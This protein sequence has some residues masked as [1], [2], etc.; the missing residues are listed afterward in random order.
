VFVIGGLALAILGLTYATTLQRSGALVALALFGQACA[1]Q[2]I[3][4]PAYDVYQHF[5]P[6][7]DA[8]RSAYLPFVLGLGAQTIIVFA[9]ASRN[10]RALATRLGQV[11]RPIEAAALLALLGFGAVV[12]SARPLQIGW[13]LLLTAWVALVGGLNVILAVEHLPSGFASGFVLKR[14][15]GSAVDLDNA[16][17]SLSKPFPWI[18]AAWTVVVSALLAWFVFE[19]VPH[20]PDDISYLFQAKY[21]ASGRLYLPAPPDAASFEVGQ[22]AVD[23]GKWFGYG[24]P[25][26][27]SVWRSASWPAF[28]GW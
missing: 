21:L 7:P 9:L 15:D 1:L 4:A 11:V 6:P 23:A 19:A 24:F 5:I 18:V 27:P 2:L 22:V 3:F 14:A 16:L 20:I 17:R 28:P 26:W 12:V 8:V 13:E 25:G 10:W